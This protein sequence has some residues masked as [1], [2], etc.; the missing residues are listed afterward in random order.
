MD[1]NQGP[2]GAGSGQAGVSWEAAGEMASR[3]LSP[4]NSSLEASVL[5]RGG[6]KLLQAVIYELRL[7]PDHPN[8]AFSACYSFL[9]AEQI[10]SGSVIARLL[11]SKAPE[12][13]S[14]AKEVQSRG[15]CWVVTETPQRNLIVLTAL[16]NLPVGG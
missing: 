9:R 13:V 5:T 4:D 8:M 2:I 3:W 11:S 1:L 16:M 14:V 12:V 15:E 10:T 6:I 7:S